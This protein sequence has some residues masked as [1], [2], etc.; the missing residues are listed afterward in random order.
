MKTIIIFITVLTLV[1]AKPVHRSVLPYYRPGRVG[2]EWTDSTCFVGWEV[3]HIVTSSTNNRLCCNHGPSVCTNLSFRED[4][5]IKVR[6][7]AA[8]LTTQASWYYAPCSLLSTV[9][10]GKL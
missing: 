1:T 5:F 7:S 10:C 4:G 9:E 2:V 3:R 6:S 8:R